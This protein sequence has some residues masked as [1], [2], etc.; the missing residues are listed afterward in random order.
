MEL[1]GWMHSCQEAAPPSTAPAACRHRPSVAK[2]HRPPGFVEEV[3]GETARDAGRVSYLNAFC[4]PSSCFTQVAT[5]IPK[6]GSGKRTKEQK[7]AQLVAHCLSVFLGNCFHAEA[8]LSARSRPPCV[9][10]A[11]L[12]RVALEVYQLGQLFPCPVL[13]S[14]RASSVAPKK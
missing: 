13:A 2:A 4:V 3:P 14:Q 8:Y 12:P 11:V 6:N 5:P 9:P 10:R 1:Q 7:Y